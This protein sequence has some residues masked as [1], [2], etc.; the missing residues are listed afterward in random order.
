MK[1]LFLVLLL[2]LVHFG[3]CNKKN[4]I[5]RFNQQN[6]CLNPILGIPLKSNLALK[7]FTFCGMYS[8]KFLRG[9]ILMALTR[10]TYL[11]MMNYGEKMG[12][13]KMYNEYIFF[14]LQK[15]SMKPDQWQHIC[16]SVSL[17]E[18]KIAMNGKIL[19]SEVQYIILIV[20][21]SM[22][23]QWWSRISMGKSLSC[24]SRAAP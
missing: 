18:V 10:D 3:S 11:W 2:H 19:K 21:A 23:G 1:I 7:E 14:D 12:A 13:L 8:F 9:R 17:Y 6:D 22:Q 4:L 20:R 5:V 24:E 16:F 15:Q